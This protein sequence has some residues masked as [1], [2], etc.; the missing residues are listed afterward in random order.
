YV[1]AWNMDQG[2][3]IYVAMLLGIAGATVSAWLIARLVSRL[4]GAQFVIATF[5]VCLLIVE[6]IKAIPALGGVQGLV[7]FSPHEGI[8]DGLLDDV[9][10]FDYIVIGIISVLLAFAV[11][12]LS[13]SPHGRRF[14]AVR[15]DLQYASSIG[16][17]VDPER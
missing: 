5:A 4:Q 10:K 3:T 12:N 13:K 9:N 7:L 16:V 8:P 1:T 2:R 14:V 6:V 15:E 17:R 11:N